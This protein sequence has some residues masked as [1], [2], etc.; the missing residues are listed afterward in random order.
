MSSFTPDDFLLTLLLK[1][2]SRASEGGPLRAETCRIDT[3]NTVVLIMHVC[4]RRF[5]YC[6]NNNVGART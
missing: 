4:S 6:V 5:F 2:T 3:V 1:C